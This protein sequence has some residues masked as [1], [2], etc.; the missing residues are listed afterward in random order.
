MH[1]GEILVVV[2]D[3]QE[4]RL[5]AGR[6]AIIPRG[7]AHAFLVTSPRA[8]MLCLQTPGTGEPF[9]RAASCS[10]DE[11]DAFGTT[12]FGLVAKAA[13]PDWTTKSATSR[14]ERSRSSSGYFLGADMTLILRGL[15][16]STN[17]GAVHNG[18]HASAL[19]ECT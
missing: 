4:S 14:T 15:R 13:A 19:T 18:I 12:D 17:P 3:R 11:T 6:I 9:Y 16:A 5:G 8:R 10:M 7:L 1:E 2:E